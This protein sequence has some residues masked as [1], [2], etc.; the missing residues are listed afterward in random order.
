MR[1]VERRRACL[2]RPAMP[3]ARAAGATGR[4]RRK[5]RKPRNQMIRIFRSDYRYKWVRRREPL[6]SRHACT[7]IG[8]DACLGGGGWAYAGA[9]T[10]S[11]AAACV[12][13][14][15]KG[16]RLMVAFTSWLP[17]L[18]LLAVAAPAL[19]AVASAPAAFPPSMAGF[20]H[21]DFTQV[22]QRDTG[23]SSSGAEDSAFCALPEMLQTWRKVS[24]CN[25][26]SGIS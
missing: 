8:R 18:N 25:K 10:D 4:R 7:R 2:S 17:L 9:A 16:R 22:E 14:C 24:G 26:S 6:P 21:D 1:A 19:V 11:G 13:C 3:P 23:A 20:V 15:G 5:S 12:S